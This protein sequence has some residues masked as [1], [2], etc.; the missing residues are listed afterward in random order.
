[1]KALISVYKPEEVPIC[2]RASVDIVD[3]KNPA[4]GSLG[5]SFP[6]I[7]SEVKRMLPSEIE[8]SVAIG[9]MPN[10]PG[11][12]SLSALGAAYSGADYVKVG[13]YG[14]REKREGIELMKGVVRSVK[15]FDSSIKVVCVGYADHFRVNAVNP[16][17]IPEIAALSDADI[18]MLDT[19]VKDGKR[20]FDSLSE[21]Q[22][23]DFVQRSRELGLKVALAGSLRIEDI[24]RIREIGADVIGFRGAVC[25]KNDRKRSLS[26]EKVKKVMKIV[27]SWD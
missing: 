14:V 19:A 11:T 20:L 22:L 26:E 16:M 9:D 24:P 5:A 13:L 7:I 23:R 15:E 1:M 27:R 12:A 21:N 8:L 3:V 18:A 10:L 25:E 2:I 17:E 6:W 4:E